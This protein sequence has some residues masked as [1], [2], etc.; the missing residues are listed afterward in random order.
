V[1]G[2]EFR[3]LGAVEVWRGGEPVVPG[4]GVM[5]NLLAVL[6][7]SANTVVTA[8]RLAAVA[9][10]DR[11]PQHPRSALHT[12]VARLR[13]VLGTDVVETVGDGYRLRTDTE[14]MDLL[15]FDDLVTSVPG[16]PDTAA[17][18]VLDEAIGLWRGTPLSNADSVVLQS[19]VVPGLV[20]RY[21][22]VCEHWAEMCLRLERPGLAAERL[23]PLVATHPFG[24]RWPRS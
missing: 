9:W 18:V 13:R 1:P 23:V 22:S 6:L 19:E 21:L 3:V 7:V 14:H 16:L 20:E 15:R 8:E 2:L 11:P 12:K 17:A 24:S 5:I 10:G 4:R